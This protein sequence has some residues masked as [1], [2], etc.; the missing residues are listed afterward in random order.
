MTDL[1][2]GAIAYEHGDRHGIAE[3]SGQLD[4]ELLAPDS[5][6]AHFRAC[7]REIHQL[8]QAAAVRTLAACPQPPDLLLYVTENDRTSSDSLVHL[9][10]SLD[11]PGIRYLR[12]SGHDCGNLGPALLLAEQAVGSG[13]HRRVL[14]LL[15]DRVL[16]GDRSQADRLSVVSDGA[17]ACLVSAEPLDAPGPRYAVHGVSTATAAAT[18]AAT[19]GGDGDRILGTVALSVTATGAITRRTGRQPADFDHLLFPNYRTISQQFL[20]SAMGAPVDR[21]L[22]GPVAEFGHCFSADVLVSLAHCADTGRIR[23]GDHVLAFGDG[24]NS[25]TSLAVER[26]G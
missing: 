6:L 13:A 17:A 3:L 23:P 24:P 9:A 18:P 8:A 21:L 11:L 10:R 5:G 26:T 19:P 25:W 7:D 2:L 14:V 15:A 20:C 16:D 4:A 22:I 12:V 1:H